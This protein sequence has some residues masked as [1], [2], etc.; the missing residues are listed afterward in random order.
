MLSRKYAQVDRGLCVACGACAKECPREAIA[1]HKGCYA[2]VDAAVCIGCGKCAK[3][4][5]ANAIALTVREGGE[6]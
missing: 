2:R 6:G 1:I 5:P 3:L 4:C